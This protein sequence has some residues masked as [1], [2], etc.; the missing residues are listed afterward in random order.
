MKTHRRH[1]AQIGQ[2]FPV[3]QKLSRELSLEALTEYAEGLLSRA[4][5]A[6]ESRR[7]IVAETQSKRIH[8]LFVYKVENSLD[9]GRSLVIQSLVLP[10]L[11]RT[12]VAT[13]LYDSIRRLAVKTGACVFAIEAPPET[14]W[15]MEFFRKQGQ[16]VIN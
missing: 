2:L 16:P 1:K 14:K 9:C 5:S 6:A 13:V 4:T 11:G 10:E 12:T 15:A 3:I 8:G 7:V